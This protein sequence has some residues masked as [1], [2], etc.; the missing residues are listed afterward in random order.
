[1]RKIIGLLFGFALFASVPVWADPLT[2][3]KQRDIQQLLEL[4]G[5]LDIGAQ[6]A[7]VVT[8]Q[9][10]EALKSARQDVPERVFVILDEEVSALLREEMAARGGLSEE[11]AAVYH[12]HFDHEEI[13]GLLQF[14]RSELGR[15]TVRVLPEVMRESMAAGRQWAQRLGAELT[16]RLEQRFKKEGIQLH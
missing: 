10:T 8:R 16:R 15:K 7:E 13:K 9:M 2:D 6:F 5:A 1:M 14:Y 4:T 12:K 11:M 3:E